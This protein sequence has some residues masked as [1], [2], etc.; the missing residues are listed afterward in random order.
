MIT[1]IVLENFKCFRKLEVNPRLITVFVGPNGT[2]KSSVLQALALLKQSLGTSE[3]RVRG[4]LLDLSEIDEVAPKFRGTFG[5]MRLEF[6]GSVNFPDLPGAGFERRVDYRY[7]AKSREGN[8]FSHSGEIKFG[9][10]GKQCLLERSESGQDAPTVAIGNDVASLARPKQ[11]ASIAEFGGWQRNSLEG[12]VQSGFAN[13]L[14]TP[15]SVLKGLRSVPAARG[16]V[17]S[18]YTLGEQNAEDIS[19]SGGLS[20]QEEQTATNLGYGREVEGRISDWLRSVTGVKLRG[21]VIP[22]K[23]VAVEV[24]SSVGAINIVAEGFGTN[25]LILLFMQLASASRGATVMIEEPEIHLHPRAQADLASLL[26][27]VAIDEDKQLIMTTHSEHILGRL[28]T[29]VAEK[30]LSPEHLA[31][32]AFEKD[33]EGVCTANELQ[34]TEDGR[35]KGGI[36]DFFESNLDEL[37]RYIKA[38]QSEE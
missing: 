12:H 31:I 36:K 26:A 20:S 6:F 34:V 32:Y 16:L 10:R 22:S 30:G 11:I 3:L 15:N 33:Q 17:R 9:F 24:L 38:L 13:I 27:G 5:S 19:L 1:G 8:G 14:D 35:V 37:D 21:K 28:L 29:M 4:D 25:A 23:A 18:A 7:A 2:G